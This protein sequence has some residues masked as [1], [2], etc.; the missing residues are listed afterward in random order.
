MI[1]A[2]GRAEAGFG[3]LS[4]AG[5]VAAALTERGH[6]VVACALG[7]A[8]NFDRD[9]AWRAAATLSDCPQPR[10]GGALVVDAYAYGSSSARAF[11]P[12][13]VLV[14]FAD[15][16]DRTAGSDL[17]ISVAASAPGAA[18]VLSGFRYACLRQQFWDLEAGD[19]ADEARSVLVSAG[20]TIA[21]LAIADAVSRR[22]S[23]LRVRVVSSR[24][25]ESGASV[26]TLV[27]PPS[28][29]GPLTEA[30]VVVTAGG[31]TLL[32]ALACG[33]PTIVLVLAEN[34]RAQAE[35]AAREGAAVLV[36][37]PEPEFVADAVAE[38]ADDPLRRSQLSAAARGLVDGRGARRVAKEVA[39]LVAEGSL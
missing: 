37:P 11:A 21:P 22:S 24:P 31:Q 15:G 29:R 23:S 39:A 35:L 6:V 28:L 3:H 13:A 20:A 34:Q 10:R 7:A 27:A 9:V 38:L 26:E 2:D 25:A 1:A 16:S 18:R 32:E 19:L 14:M 5:A 36:D 8:H 12:D 4:R 30:D 33:R 17:A